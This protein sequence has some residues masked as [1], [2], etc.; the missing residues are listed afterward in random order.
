M[1]GGQQGLLAD[2][3]GAV[4]RVAG[5]LGVPATDTARSFID[6]SISR[7]GRCA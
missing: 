7:T 6:P 4:E 5:F 1:N 3:C 2:P